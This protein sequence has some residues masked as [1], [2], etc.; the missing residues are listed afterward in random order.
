MTI[1]LLLCQFGFLLFLFLVWLLWLGLP[2]LWWIKVVRV[3]IL[4]LSWSERKCFQLFTIEYDVGC[5]FVIYDICYVEVCSL[6][7]HFVE[8]FYCKWMVN[9]VKS[10]FCTYWDDYMIF[11]L[12]F[13]NMVYHTNW[14]AN[15][16]L[17]LH[18][19]D[20]FHFIILYDPVNVLLNSYC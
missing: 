2:V 14:F 12:H 19:W 3:D 11:I 9:F 5:G 13:V 10:F 1:L 16:E 8:R 17:Y 15:I 7:T 18:P 20:K 6:H 4:V